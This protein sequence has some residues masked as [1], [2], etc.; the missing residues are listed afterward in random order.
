MK[1]EGIIDKT[2]RV[3]LSLEVLPKWKAELCKVGFEK[4]P[5]TTIKGILNPSPNISH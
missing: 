4:D 3:M 1:S 5:T 2:Q